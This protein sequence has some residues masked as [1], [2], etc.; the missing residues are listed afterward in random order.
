MNKSVNLSLILF[1]PYTW[2]AT[3]QEMDINNILD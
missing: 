1:V 2:F 3:G